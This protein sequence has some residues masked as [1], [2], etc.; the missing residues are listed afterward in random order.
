MSV[1]EVMWCVLDAKVA[2][3]DIQQG[4]SVGRNCGVFLMQKWP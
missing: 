1:R 3:T 2:L 4:K